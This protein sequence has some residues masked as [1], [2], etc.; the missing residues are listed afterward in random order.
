MW[1]SKIRS[2]G[3]HQDNKNLF[4]ITRVP[5]KRVVNKF[6]GKDNRKFLISRFLISGLYCIEICGMPL[7]NCVMVLVAAP[8][9]TEWRGAVNVGQFQGQGAHNGHEY[10]GPDAR[11][12]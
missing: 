2:Y 1:Y 4:L 8:G 5:Y 3:T 7:C 6:L 12:S 10:T 11:Q 9:P